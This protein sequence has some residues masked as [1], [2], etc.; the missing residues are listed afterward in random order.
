V[1]RRKCPEKWR[2][3]GLSLIHDNAPAHQ[4]VSVKDFLAKNNVTTLEHSQNS[5]DLVPANFSPFPNLKSALKGR[6]FYDA[7]DIMK[8]AMEKL[9]RHSQ[10]GLEKRFQHFYSRCKK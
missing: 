4:S 7:T 10:N 1:V 6:S 2:T 8:N 3:N 9:K 5:P